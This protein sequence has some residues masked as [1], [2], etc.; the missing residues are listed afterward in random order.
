M[1]EDYQRVLDFWFGDGSDA[2]VASGQSPLWWGKNP[3]T[4]RQIKKEFEG[5]LQA[6]ADGELQQWLATPQGRLAAIIVLDQFSRNMY[7]DSGQSFAQDNLALT[8]CLEGMDSGADKKLSNIQ[9]VF[10]YMPLEHA[11]SMEMQNLSVATFEQLRDQTPPENKK[12]FSGFVGFA[13]KHRII[14]ERFGRYPHRNKL[15]GRESTVKEV[16]FLKQPGSSF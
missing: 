1:S 6:L 10:F 13:E 9:R 12:L 14:I 15:L 7:R 11:E 5:D 2:D 16:E 3:D 8:L 4:D